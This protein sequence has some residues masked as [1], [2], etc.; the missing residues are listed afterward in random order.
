MLATLEG[1]VGKAI[2]VSTSMAADDGCIIMIMSFQKERLCDAESSIQTDSV[3]GF[4]VGDYCLTANVRQHKCLVPT[5][6]NGN[7]A[8]PAHM[9]LGH[10]IAT[11][12]TAART[13][14]AVKPQYKSFCSF[15]S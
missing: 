7:S 10:K 5:I 11:T 13:S 9:M 14:Q 1:R 2:I 6:E 3:E 12:V 8:E 4:L 15:L